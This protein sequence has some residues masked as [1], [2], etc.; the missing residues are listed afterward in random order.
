MTV[1]LA[2]IVFVI[3]S[4]QCLFISVIFF[5]LSSYSAEQNSEESKQFT[6]LSCI[7]FCHFVYCLF[8]MSLDSFEQFFLFENGVTILFLISMITFYVKCKRESPPSNFLYILLIAIT[9]LCM[10]VFNF[11]DKGNTLLESPL[12]LGVYHVTTFTCIFLGVDYLLHGEAPI[13]HRKMLAFT[14]IYVSSVA[15][16][17]PYVDAG[18]TVFWLIRAVDIV[19]IS[20]ILFWILL[21]NSLL[22]SESVRF[23]LA[24]EQAQVAVLMLYNNNQV[25]YQNSTFVSRYNPFQKSDANHLPFMQSIFSVVDRKLENQEGWQ[26]NTAFKIGEEEVTVQIFA[27]GLYNAS[28]DILLK[29]YSILDTTKQSRYKK[30]LETYGKQLS[31]L[32]AKLLDIQETE[33]AHIARELHDDIGQ[34]L[35]LIK[36]SISSDRDLSSNSELFEKVENALESVRGLSRQLR[37]VILDE[38]GL[39]SALKW[40]VRQIKSTQT[41]LILSIEEPYSLIPHPIDINLFRL[42][43]EIVN[44]ALK[45]ANANTIQ[46][47]LLSTREVIRLIVSD[48]GEGFN[49]ETESSTINRTQSFG[50]LSIKERVKLMNGR[51]DLTSDPIKGTQYVIEVF[52]ESD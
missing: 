45:H 19:L 21:V 30:L 15:N 24:F 43:Q 29:V 47:T 23:K 35:T 13:K 9:I 50:L 25:A 42:I 2:N 1:D 26:G 4:V 11:S 31:D 27:H 36:F 33:R 6:L 16:L 7:F 20:Y 5:S 3:L 22:H 17:T 40:F 39:P 28:G 48:D 8:S 10:Y 32:S 52:H 41:K 12:Y 37:P 46:I 34:Q 51:I 14:T 38:M 18:T 44:N 49:V